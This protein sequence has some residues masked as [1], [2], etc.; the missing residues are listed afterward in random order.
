MK[1]EQINKTTI[2]YASSANLSVLALKYREENV[3]SEIII[4]ELLKSP[5]MNWMGSDKE[6]LHGPFRVDSLSVEDFKSLT[7]EDM[8]HHTI[9][10][11]QQSILDKEI[12]DNGSKFLE[13]VQS[14]FMKVKSNGN[15]YYEF[16]Y[17]FDKSTFDEGILLE[18]RIRL[19]D[20]FPFSVFK[21]CI[22]INHALQIVYKIEIADD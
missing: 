22:I 2:S 1:F 20:W 11:I 7:F 16:I 4:E 13:S 14:E 5:F 9:E 3:A 10:F 6:R 8:L 15:E 21:S 19:S 17:V 12:E 18:K